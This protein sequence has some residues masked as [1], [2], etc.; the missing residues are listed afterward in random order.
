MFVQLELNQ[1]NLF[2]ETAKS[3]TLDFNFIETDGPFTN[4][5]IIQGMSRDAY[6]AH[7]M[8]KGNTEGIPLR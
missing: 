4:K 5:E 2:L 3:E 8:M 7:M 1:I 6:G